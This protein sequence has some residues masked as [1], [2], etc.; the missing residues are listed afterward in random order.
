MAEQGSIGEG[1]EL[2]YILQMQTWGELRTRNFS[3]L[4]SMLPRSLTLFHKLSSE[5]SPG[6]PLLGHFHCSIKYLGLQYS[7]R[8]MNYL[9]PPPPSI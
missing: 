6:R 5:F 7:G 8:P 9:C 2:I 3:F 1:G 4:A